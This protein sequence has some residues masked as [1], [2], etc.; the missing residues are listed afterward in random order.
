MQTMKE[1]TTPAA[2]F[3]ARVQEERARLGWGRGEM[4][5]RLA[6]VGHKLDRATLA[7]I[8]KGRRQDVKLSE[9]LAFAL[10]FEV[11]PL[12][13]MFPREGE[14][15]VALTPEVT[16]RADQAWGWAFHGSDPRSI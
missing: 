11:S 16:I 6:E 8:E 2:I 5:Q 10:V 12:S 1:A 13:L 14:A 15:L 9:V 3:A 7:D 4:A